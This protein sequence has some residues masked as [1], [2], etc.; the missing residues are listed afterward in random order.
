MP[1]RRFA[2][3]PSTLTLPL[4]P[5]AYHRLYLADPCLPSSAARPPFRKEE[6]LNLCGLY[7]C[8]GPALLPTAPVPACSAASNL[9]RSLVQPLPPAASLGPN[10]SSSASGK[11]TL[12]LTP[13]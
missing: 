1:S 3:E 13:R 12:I 6:I 4:S 8:H 2:C 10:N 11:Q 7:F 5:R 9:P